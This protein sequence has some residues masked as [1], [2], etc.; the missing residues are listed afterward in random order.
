MN[1]FN[2][3]NYTNPI[4]VDIHS[5]LLPGID[6]GVR[7]IEES[8]A[9]IKKFKLLGYRR[10]ITTPHIISDLYPNNRE[11]ITQKLQD[12]QTALKKEN[13]DISIE[14]SA[15]YYVDMEFL[16]LIE[17]DELIPFNGNYILFETAYGSKPM[18]L[19]Q[20]IHSLQAKGYIPVLA[21]PERYRYLHNDI[22]LYK[23]LK[24]DGV[25]FQVNIKSLQNRSKTI[26]KMALKLIQL[27]LVDFMGSDVH[28]MHDIVKLKKTLQ[29]TA[30]RN[31]IK[32]NKLLNN[33]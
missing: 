23:S 7:T 2:L 1:F 18:I 24:A 33:K 8:V 15:E 22:E 9:I 14:A 10:L 28:K 3:F 6:D 29:S 20:V 16:K 32:K 11:I 13:I 26:C 21:H 5:H 25:L 31:A 30:Y 27:G 12:V 17:D 19:D 4:T